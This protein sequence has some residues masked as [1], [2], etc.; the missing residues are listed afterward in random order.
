MMTMNISWVYGVMM[1]SY[2]KIRVHDD[3]KGFIEI[4]T[5]SKNELCRG[6]KQ[7]MDEQKKLIMDR[8]Y[9]LLMYVNHMLSIAMLTPE[10]RAKYFD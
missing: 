5:L 4:G 1:M 6:V 2:K 8:E 7:L 9:V 3:K 10:E